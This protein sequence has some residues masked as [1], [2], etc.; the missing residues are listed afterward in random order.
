[1]KFTFEP[2]ECANQDYLTSFLTLV[3]NY[4]EHFEGA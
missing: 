1:M 3:H 2:T 4:L